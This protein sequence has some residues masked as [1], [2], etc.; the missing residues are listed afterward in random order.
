MIALN[1]TGQLI[2]GHSLPQRVTL[3][4]LQQVTKV[5]Y[6]GVIICYPCS[7]AEEVKMAVEV[8]FGA[9]I[10][11]RRKTLDL[12]REQLAQCAGCSVSALRKIEGDERRPSR[13]LAE[14]LATCLQI[15][16]DQRPLFL[17]TARGERRVERLGAPLL[18]PPAGVKSGL[19]RPVLNLPLPPTPL[20]GRE[21]ELAT[22]A[23]LLRDPP[24]RLLTLVGP[25]GIGKTRLALATASEQQMLFPNGVYFVS[26]AS[27]TSAQFIIPAIADS[28]DFTFSG[29]VEPKI[30]LLHYLR[31][32]CLL[33][34][35]DN[36]EHLLEAGPLL[37]ELL[38]Q[39]PAVKLLVT[40][41]ERLNLQGEWLFDLHGLPVPPPDQVDRVEAYSAVGLFVQSARRVQAGFELKAE[42]RLAVAHICQM[43]EGMPLAI[44]LAAAWVRVLSYVEIAAE[45]ERNLDFLAGAARDAPGRHRSLRVA[46]DHSWKL[47]AQDER[48]ALCRLAVFQGGFERAAA[49]QIA[50]ASL[51]VLSALVDK[52]LLRR[53]EGGRYDLHE[54]VRQYA[55]A[56]LTDEA[57]RE[58]ATRDR[59]CEFYLALLQSRESDLKNAA[60]RRA[61]RELTDEIDNIRAAWAWAV[62]C[63][64]FEL[65]GPSV[66]G[67][68]R[69]FELGGWL[70]DG[71]EY[72]EPV[73]QALWANP[74]DKAEQQ[75]LGQTLAYQALLFFR[76]GRFSQALSL[77]DDSLTFLRPLNN[78]ALLTH[79]LVYSGIILHLNG[80]I[81]L[82]QARLD[83]GLVCAE[84]AG[85]AWFVAYA[86]LNQGYIASLL[87]RYQEGYEQMRQSLISMRAI[88]DPHALTLGLNFISPTIIHLS[89]YEEAEACLQESLALC[90]ELGNRWGM[91]TAYRFLGLAALAQ[92]KLPEAET[93]IHYSLDVFNDLVRGWDIV[94]SLIYLG[95]AKA[96]TGD[97]C[98]ARR[99]FLQALRIAMEAQAIPLVLDTLVGLAYL[100]AQAGEVEQAL[101]LSTCVLGHPAGAQEAK[102]RAEQLV[103]GLEAQ[104]T[105][106]QLEAFQS[107]EVGGKTFDATV[108]KLLNAS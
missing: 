41:R 96:A 37:A 78:P 63:K 42:D 17:Q 83:E 74:K 23:R 85:D 26:L 92:N 51:P 33:L 67:F 53:E 94:R 77:F 58:P 4:V 15:P 9:W 95:Q 64:K 14:R 34:V 24:C 62:E 66:T 44:E 18:E 59:H 30:Q 72:M 52:S 2:W 1:H 48:D 35:L 84:A 5:C 12:T 32:Q 25:G 76:W 105:P 89:R 56:H 22:L 8:S 49:E 101:K 21:A 19:S 65:I 81:T 87:G 11:K 13:Q 10:G 82:A 106:E 36:L 57:G 16:P 80:E 75:V 108:A 3:N 47:L 6:N 99:I 86:R 103:A 107:Q 39:A 60:L 104:L 55:L 91:G 50:S 73:V 90:T 98:E 70:S 28:L 45:I 97:W 43:V 68:G 71:I 88:G 61:L 93:L 29:P 27:L 79:S 7:P 40:S 31:E 100:Q 69:L 54:V 46:F 102:D 38:R 20:L